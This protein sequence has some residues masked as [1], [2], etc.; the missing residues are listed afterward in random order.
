VAEKVHLV[1]ICGSGMRALAMWYWAKGYVVDGCDA[2]LTGGMDELQ[3]AVVTVHPGHDPSHVEGCQKVV[4][5]AAVPENHP[6]LRRARDLGLTVLRRSEALAELT[7]GT[8]LLAVAGAHGKT[9]TTAMT[10]WILEGNG[11]DPTV[12]LGGKVRPWKGNFRSGSSITVVEADEYDRAFLRLRPSAAAVTTFALDHLECYGTP[13]ALSMAFGIFLEMTVPGGTVIVPREHAELAHWAGRIGRRVVTTGPRGDYH[14]KLLDRDGWGMRFELD[15]VRGRIPVPGEHNLVNAETAVALAAAVGIS[16]RDAVGALESFPGVERRME[17]IGDFH[18][19]T[20][21][22][23]YAHHP[24]EMKAALDAA[25]GLAEGPVGIVF[26]PHLFSRTAMHGSEMGRVLADADWSLVLPVY[27]AREKPI[28]GVTAGLVC[29]ACTKAGGDCA[30]VD[31][32][33]L[34]EELSARKA[35]I[36]VFMGAGSVDSLAREIAELEKV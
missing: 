14:C 36:V 34:F 7:D 35:G 11:L 21:V 24:D 31:P 15:G 23:D 29:D 13:E 1:G 19:M 9:T 17:R 4:F 16:T 2:D 6:E 10:G 18:G 33:I 8:H 26:Q 22:S 28:P 25:A 27:P 3:S 32:G 20:I 30:A 5:S 12:M